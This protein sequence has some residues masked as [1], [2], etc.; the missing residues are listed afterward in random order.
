MCRSGGGLWQ[1]LLFLLLLLPGLDLCLALELL[2][3]LFCS[4][5]SD[6]SRGGRI[7]FGSGSGASGVMAS[8]PASRFDRVGAPGTLSITRVVTVVARI[9]RSTAVSTVSSGRSF[10]GSLSVARAIAEWSFVE[11]A[12]TASSRCKKVS[13]LAVAISLRMCELAECCRI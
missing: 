2:A 7:R 4:L 10:S 1:L 3:F 12:V 11:T 9:T 8:S 5:V 6:L 13:V